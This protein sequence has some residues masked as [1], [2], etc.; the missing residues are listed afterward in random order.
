M[1]T[2]DYV[3]VPPTSAEIAAHEEAD[4]RARRLEESQYAHLPTR[5]VLC[6]DEAHFL[7][8]LSAPEWSL[9]VWVDIEVF[10][11]TKMYSCHPGVLFSREPIPNFEPDGKTSDQCHIGWFV[12]KIDSYE[13]R[14]KVYQH[15]N[16]H[17]HRVRLGNVETWKC[18]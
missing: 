18:S 4:E 11:A 13:Q 3:F 15:L 12:Y 5:A 16:R 6:R 14:A 9:E 1:M 10:V 2:D 7:D 17:H 8:N